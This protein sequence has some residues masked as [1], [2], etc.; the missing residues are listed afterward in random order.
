MVTL[1]GV[2]MINEVDR[3]NDDSLKALT[4]L[5]W[6]LGKIVDVIRQFLLKD[7]IFCKCGSTSTRIDVF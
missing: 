6:F 7:M 5:L 2:Q 1:L 3:I 4:C